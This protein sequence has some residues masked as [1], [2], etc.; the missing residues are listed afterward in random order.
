MSNMNSLNEF[1]SNSSSTTTIIVVV[2]RMLFQYNEYIV[3]KIE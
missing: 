1:H 2:S 3:F